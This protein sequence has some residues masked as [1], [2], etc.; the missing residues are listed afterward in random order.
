MEHSL[1]ISLPF[2]TRKRDKNN[3]RDLTTQFFQINR[4]NILPRKRAR[5]I[6]EVS[7]NKRVSC[8]NIQTNKA[9]SVIFQSAVFLLS[10]GYRVTFPSVGPFFL[11]ISDWTNDNF[12]Q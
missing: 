10:S 3:V 12:P 6:L 1:Y 9:S 8:D 5:T 7:E 2:S 4:D 11:G